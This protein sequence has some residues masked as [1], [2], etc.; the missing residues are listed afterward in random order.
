MQMGVSSVLSE[1]CFAGRCLSSFAHCK[2]LC[3]LCMELGGFSGPPQQQLSNALIFCLAGGASSHG[4]G[5]KDI[6]QW[7]VLPDHGSPC[8]APGLGLCIDV[9]VQIL[10]RHPG[11]DELGRSA[12]SPAGAASQAA[13]ACEVAAAVVYSFVLC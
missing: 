1:G 3:G 5:T 13:S 8:P 11:R 12:A 4:A 9:C 10:L 2:P 7:G 6:A